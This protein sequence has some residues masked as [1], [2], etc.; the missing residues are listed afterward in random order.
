MGEIK[1]I[2][3]IKTEQ[4]VFGYFSD[5]LTRYILKEITVFNYPDGYV[6][7][8]EVLPNG[9]VDA[10][11]MEIFLEK[12]QKEHP[13]SRIFSE[14]EML[15]DFLNKAQGID[16]YVK[17]LRLTSSAFEFFEK[18]KIAK[19]YMDKCEKNK[20]PEYLTFREEVDE[21]NRRIETSK[22]VQVKVVNVI[23]G[24]F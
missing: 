5:A 18:E 11:K 3:K 21:I 16:D 13:R 2:E 20:W 10:S 23:K 19:I 4:K 24:F 17:L 14:E 12:Q 9:M 1:E 22:M 6:Q 8:K 7:V 15:S